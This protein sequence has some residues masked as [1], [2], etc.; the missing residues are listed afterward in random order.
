MPEFVYHTTNP[1]TVEVGV[2]YFLPS[3]YLYWIPHGFDMVEFVLSADDMKDSLDRIVALEEAAED[4]CK[5]IGVVFSR[6]IESDL[7]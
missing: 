6:V 7:W 1:T 3:D 2:E 4:W 5:S